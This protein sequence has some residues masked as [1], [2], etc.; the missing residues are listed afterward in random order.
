MRNNKLPQLFK[1]YKAIIKL[2]SIRALYDLKGYTRIDTRY[3]L[4]DHDR[5]F[6][7]LELTYL[8]K[9]YDDR[10]HRLT[11][12]KFRKILKPLSEE[13][14][15]MTDLRQGS[16]FTNAE[17]LGRLA[18]LNS[19]EVSILAFGVL[20]NAV[21]E[22]EDV[23]DILGNISPHAVVNTLSVILQ[24]DRTAVRKAIS[25]D[26]LLHRTGLLRVQ[27]EDRTQ[28][29]YQMT[30]MNEISGVLLDDD[31]PNIMK[32]LTRFF[33]LS[34]AANLKK[35]DFDHVKS[36]FNLLSSYLESTTLKRKKG[37][38]I[39]V[40]GPPGTGKTE[41]VRTLAAQ[42]KSTLY[43]VTTDTGETDDDS[44]YRSRIDSYRLCQQVLKRKTETIILFDEI[45]DT[46][47]RDG[48]MERFGIRTSTDAKKGS[49]NHLLETNPLP[50]IWVSNVVSHIDEAIIRRFDYVMELKIPPQSTRINIIKKYTEGLDVSDKWIKQISVNEHLAPALISRAAKVIKELAYV[51]QS[52]IEEGMERVL[53]NTL[54]AM[55]HDKVL[56]NRHSSPITYRLDAL[57]PDYNLVNLQKALMSKAQG[58]FCLYGPSGTGKSEFARHL[59][60]ELDKPLLIKRASDLLDPYI[61]MTEKNLS[62]MF[63]QAKDEES[64]L[65]LDEADS[66][67]RD[68]SRSRESWEVTQVNELLTQMEQFKGLFFCTTNLMETLDQASLRRFDLKIKFDYLKPDQTWTLFKQTLEDY[69]ENE[70]QLEAYKSK[71]Q[72]LQGVTPGDFATV[73][74]QNRFSGKPLDAEALQKGLER[75]IK[76]KQYGAFKGIGFIAN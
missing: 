56:S 67:L 16:L 35:Q 4:D 37:I 1:Q 76:F 33:V 39:L 17:E 59:A 34:K 52:K 40:F 62:N 18:G 42:L 22:I 64:L 41:M 54:N 11:K 61:G 57:N 30:V 47:I 32:S 29:I 31:K 74:R 7:I 8:P 26:S 53:G 44:T 5:V 55:G 43:E 71:I 48:S 24:L 19:A 15:V 60:K 10:K 9:K 46:F 72:A 49:F 36:D 50:T 38:N 27:R 73:A 51:E 68:R 12:K 66:F 75:E 14:E 28:L 25:S 2:W 3:D 20:L 70:S 13:Y 6:D 69:H 58:R 21:R 65:L 63:E 45:E 23:T